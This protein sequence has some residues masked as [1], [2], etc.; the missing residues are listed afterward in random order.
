[1]KATRLLELQHRKVAATFAH[2]ES[3]EDHERIHREE[4]YMGK[5]IRQDAE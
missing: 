2:L 4:H 5:P 3:L 1:M